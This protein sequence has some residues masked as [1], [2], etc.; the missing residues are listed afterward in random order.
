VTLHRAKA[1]PWAI[2]LEVERSRLRFPIQTDVQAFREAIGQ[3]N[4]QKAI[5]LHQ[6][7]FLEG[8]PIL[9]SPGFEQWVLL[10]REALLRAWKGAVLKWSATLEANGEH[11]SAATL[12]LELLHVD[13]LAEDVLQAYMRAAYQ[14]GQRDAALKNFMQFSTYLEQE[15]GLAPMQETLVLLEAIRAASPIVLKPTQHNKSS[16]PITV[17]RPPRL[18]GRDLEHS[19]LMVAKVALVAGEPGV[20]KTR[21]LQDAA[22]NALWLRCRDGLENVPFFPVV[23]HLKTRLETLPNLGVYRQD[24]A[25]L[26]PELEP[27]PPPPADPQTSKLRLMEALARVLESQ[28]NPLVVDDLQWAD[29]GTLELLVFVVLRGQLRILGAYRDT[30]LN[31]AL[32]RTIE[33]LKV[34]GQHFHLE[35]LTTT[36]LETLLLDLSRQE[37][38]PT[39]FSAWLHHQTGGNPFFALETLRGL[40]EAGVLSADNNSWNTLLDE[41]SRD[42]TELKVPPKVFEVINRRFSRLPETTQRV[43]QAASVIR[44]NF[45]PK[46]LSSVAGISEFAVLDA[47]EEAEQAH[48]L[49]GTVFMHDLIRQGIYSG[50]HE[51]R[52]K[53]VHARVA[54]LLEGNAEPALVAE[55]WYEAGQK[56]QAVEFWV[57]AASRLGEISLYNDQIRICQR[58]LKHSSE[59][60]KR[61]QARLDCIAAHANAGRYAKAQDEIELGVR[62][63]DDPIALAR[64]A[65]IQAD[66][67]S[68]QGQYH[69]ALEQLSGFDPIPDWFDDEMNED[70]R[71]IKSN[72]FGALGHYQ[73]ALEMLEADHMRYEQSKPSWK[74]TS[75]LTAIGSIYDRLED[76]ENALGF[77][78]RALQIAKTI[79]NLYG[80]LYAMRN[81]LFTLRMLGRSEEGIAPA[82]VLLQTPHLAQSDFVRFNL[83]TV[84]LGLGRYEEAQGHYEHIIEHSHATILRIAALGRISEV[85]S[86]LKMDEQVGAVLNMALDELLT[87]DSP[88]SRG[89]VATCVYKHGNEDQVT[90]VEMLFESFDLEQVQPDVRTS[91]HEAR[92]AR[93]KT[94]LQASG[95]VTLVS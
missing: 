37:S 72:A 87:T 35:P 40:F 10:E 9:D 85:Y 32:T 3:A 16:V 5:Q 44:E 51:A 69:K 15:L 22:P 4:W 82:E 53:L 54:Q 80:Q 31:P 88:T 19:S 28:V 56:D 66:V 68:S 41:I 21:L 47:L 64:L 79:E 55:H 2:E 33:A 46:L 34:H 86:A 27:D 71:W 20:G 14:S 65:I 58:I 12:L 23:E 8:F 92:A 62:E 94:T 70:L 57:K 6:R 78:Q 36:D 25:R 45:N 67:F 48:L 7:P 29:E 17:Q 61:N 59:Q 63:T 60:S 75:S 91:F 95:D 11:A 89:I 24:L 52:C 39:Q 42:Y 30:E 81:L 50:L 90:R 73:E 1:Q 49:R 43:L 38:K 84:Y 76:Y 83:A 93:L 74:L 13:A 26:I 18:I 77:H